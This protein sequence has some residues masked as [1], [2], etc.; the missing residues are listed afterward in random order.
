MNV[1]FLTLYSQLV[2]TET[3]SCRTLSASWDINVVF[4]ILTHLHTHLL[5]VT[6]C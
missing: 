5:S 6:H 2:S 3:T 1:E 4:F